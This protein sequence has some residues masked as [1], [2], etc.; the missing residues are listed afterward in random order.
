MRKQFKAIRLNN[1]GISRTLTAI[2]YNRSNLERR[3]ATLDAPR[4]FGMHYVQGSTMSVS[5]P[6]FRH[7]NTIRSTV[8]VLM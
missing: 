2:I 7:D 6:K 4:N 5:G 8:R 1:W 3:V